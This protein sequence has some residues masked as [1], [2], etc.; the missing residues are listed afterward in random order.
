MP[1]DD[2]FVTIAGLWPDIKSIKHA[3]PNPT[4]FIGAKG[5]CRTGG[6]G[7]LPTPMNAMVDALRQ[8]GEAL[9][10]LACRLDAAA[11]DVQAMM[12]QLVVRTDALQGSPAKRADTSADSACKGPR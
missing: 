5:A 9:A 3:V 10:L 11:I 6:T 7:V 8:G 12:Q 2:G 1:T 4:N